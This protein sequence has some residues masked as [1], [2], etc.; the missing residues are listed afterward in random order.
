MTRNAEFGIWPMKSKE[1]G[2]SDE[3]I[4]TYEERLRTALIN[5]SNEV[6]GGY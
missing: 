6:V 1:W 2:M 5:L 4:K 3:T